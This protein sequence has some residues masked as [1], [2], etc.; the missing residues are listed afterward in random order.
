MLSNQARGHPT[1]CGR[2][3]QDEIVTGVLCRADHQGPSENTQS[4]DAAVAPEPG[5][6]PGLAMRNSERNFQI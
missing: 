2:A 5:V 3:R 4:N 6:L 1:Q